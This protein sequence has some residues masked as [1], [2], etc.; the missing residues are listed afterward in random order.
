ML[1]NDQIKITANIA[2]IAYC[3]IDE[4]SHIKTLAH[5]FFCELAKKVFRIVAD[6]KEERW[7]KGKAYQIPA[8]KL[9]NAEKNRKNTRNNL[10]KKILK[11]YHFLRN[12][13]FILMT[14][15]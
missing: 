7:R 10:Y 1:L 2:D 15:A 3:L 6:L 12:I 11:F 5:G 8:K 13:L 9:E 4:E 14:A